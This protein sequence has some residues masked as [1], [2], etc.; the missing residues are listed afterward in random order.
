M[1]QKKLKSS[2]AGNRTRGS[3][4]KGLNVT[5]YTTLDLSFQCQ[6]SHRRR[7]EIGKCQSSGKKRS[8]QPDSNQ[9]PKEIHNYYSPPLYQLSY[10]RIQVT[11][12]QSAFVKRRGVV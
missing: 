9:R 2:N 3:N 8:G 1:C 5:D 4:V 7:K 10:A 6:R 12:S 11:L